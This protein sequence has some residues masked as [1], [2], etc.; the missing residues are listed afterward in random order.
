[1]ARVCSVSGKK[2]TFGNKVSHA[3]NKSRRR[4]QPN[5]Q[6]CS[7]PSEILGKPVSLRLTANG[8]RTV[9]HN[10]GI[11]SWLLG[12]RNSRLSEPALK[13]KKQITKAQARK[14]AA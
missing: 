12:T 1:M 2:P 5:L 11:D 13:I 6:M 8:I 9:E 3:N 14:K 7:F 10:G 4:W